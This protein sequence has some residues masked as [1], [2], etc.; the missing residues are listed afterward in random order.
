MMR[1]LVFKNLTS[2]N[3]RMKILSTCESAERDGLRH[4]I[5]RHFLYVVKELRED[6]TSLKPQPSL[7]VRK[8]RSSAS[9]SEVFFCKLKG[10]V[11]AVNEER[12]F[13]INYMHTL[14]ISVTTVPEYAPRVQE[15]QE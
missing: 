3:R 4:V 11:Y 8:E 7:I 1:D 9:H 13:L 6:G 2:S 15:G 12:M 14:R 10:S 5:N